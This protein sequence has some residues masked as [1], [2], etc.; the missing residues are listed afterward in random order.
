MMETNKHDVLSESKSVAR[1]QKYVHIKA[2]L[3]NIYI[4]RAWRQVKMT[5]IPV[6]RKA[7]FTE[8]EGYQ[9]ISLLSFMQKRCKNW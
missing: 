8:A 5:F 1:Y 7:N 6:P 4:P 9:P 2:C 3:G